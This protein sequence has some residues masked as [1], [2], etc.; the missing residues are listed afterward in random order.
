MNKP[1]DVDPR[2]LVSMS[3][4][5]LIFLPKSVRRYIGTIGPQFM[6]EKYKVILYSCL[7]SVTERI[8]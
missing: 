8:K 3:E 1:G 5:L 2:Y 4:T 6:E 7:S